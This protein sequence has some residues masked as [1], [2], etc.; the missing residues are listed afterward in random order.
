MTVKPAKLTIHGKYFTKGKK[1][2]FNIQDLTPPSLHFF[3]SLRILT[4][5][6]CTY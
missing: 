2:K 5:Y 1:G 4:K 3:C 6:T